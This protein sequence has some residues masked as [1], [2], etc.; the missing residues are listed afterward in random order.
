MRMVYH[1]YVN[2]NTH[3]VVTGTT[4]FYTLVIFDFLQY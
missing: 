3:P 4:G 2:A 1:S